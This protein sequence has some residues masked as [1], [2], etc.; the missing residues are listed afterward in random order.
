MST[1]SDFYNHFHVLVFFFLNHSILFFT[2]WT[3][4]D[5]PEWSSSTVVPNQGW[6]C[7]QGIPVNGKRGEK[8]H[9]CH[10]IPS[11]RPSSTGLVLHCI[12]YSKLVTVSQAS[13]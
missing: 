5:L 4:Q 3:H 6:L 9:A 7:P 13:S 11:L 2:N 10:H 12:P 8:P 1:S